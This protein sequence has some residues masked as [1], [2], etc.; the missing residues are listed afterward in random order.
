M[1]RK[2]RAFK[3]AVTALGVQQRFIKPCCLWTNGQVERFN[4]MLQAAWPYR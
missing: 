4:R 3:G 1:Y 2:S